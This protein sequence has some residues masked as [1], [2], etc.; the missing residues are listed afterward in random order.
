M[1]NEGFTLVELIAII[2]VLTVILLIGIPKILEVIDNNK[3]SII[4]SNCESY[5]K[6][7]E[8][9]LIDDQFDGPVPR[10]GLYEVKDIELTKAKGEMPTDGWLYVIDGTVKKAEL[11]FGYHVVEYNG[12]KV[13]INDKKEVVSPYTPFNG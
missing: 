4:K 2:T 6:V 5:I 12:K 1:K 7:F 8:D 13:K 11:Q 10:D 3:L 9:Q